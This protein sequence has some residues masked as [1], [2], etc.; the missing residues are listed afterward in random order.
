MSLTAEN[1]LLHVYFPRRLASVRAFPLGNQEGQEVLPTCSVTMLTLIEYYELGKTLGLNN[2]F[3]LYLL[4]IFYFLNG[5]IGVFCSF[6]PRNTDFQTRPWEWGCRED[7]PSRT[8]LG[9]NKI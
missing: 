9:Q 4:P 5:N 7:V 8:P 1:L 6:P 3:Q 2:T